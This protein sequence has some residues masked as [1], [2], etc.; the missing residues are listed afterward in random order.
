MLQPKLSGTCFHHS[1]THHPSVV[2]SLEL[3]WKPISSHKPTGTSENFCWRVYYFT[4]TFTYRNK[5]SVMSDRSNWDV[6]TNTNNDIQTDV[7]DGIID[8]GKILHSSIWQWCGT[9]GCCSR[10]Q[11]THLYICIVAVYRLWQLKCTNAH[12]GLTAILPVNPDVSLI[13]LLFFL[14]DSASSQA[15]YIFSYPP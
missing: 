10:K 4:F 5:R 2:D 11:I 15:D 6:I 7:D 3:G 1:S 12:I 9:S 13:F 8:A 14:Q